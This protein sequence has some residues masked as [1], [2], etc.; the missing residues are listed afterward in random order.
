MYAKVW[1]LQGN[2]HILLIFLKVIEVNT[3]PAAN[4]YTANV[5]AEWSKDTKILIVACAKV[6]S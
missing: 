6:S 4:Y 2:L 3:S 1:A 5:D